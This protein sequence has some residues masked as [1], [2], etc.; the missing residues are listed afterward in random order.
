MNR[1]YVAPKGTIRVCEFCK[2]QYKQKTTWQRYCSDTCTTKAYRQRNGLPIVPDFAQMKQESFI[3]QQKERLRSDNHRMYELRE[4]GK[5]I[6]AELRIVDDIYKLIQSGEHIE[7]NSKWLE[8]RNLTKNTTATVFHTIMSSM[9]NS[10]NTI[11]VEHINNTRSRLMQEYK[12]IKSE[13]E[14]I[15]S[16]WTDVNS[17]ESEASK[18]SDRIH[19]ANIRKF[20]H[21][22][23]NTDKIEATE[24]AVVS[25]PLS[26]SDIVN[27][28][29]TTLYMGKYDNLMGKVEY[30]TTIIISGNQGSGKTTFSLQ[31]C[32][33]F[34][35]LGHGQALYISPEQIRYTTAGEQPTEALANVLRRNNIT[36]NIAFTGVKSFNAISDRILQTKA[37]LVVIDS[38]TKTNIAVEDRDNML[39]LHN[40]IMFMF[41]L[42]G[43]KAG[44][45]RGSSMWA[46]DADIVLNAEKGTIESTKNRYCPL[47]KHSVF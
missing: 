7:A 11:M 12:S 20:R 47:A 29:Y 16:Y 14:Q 44:K 18:I 23:G 1:Q 13:Y 15:K 24:E 36:Q 32:D 40:N 31:L 26:L 41:I 28:T 42:Q 25:S 21:S 33:E 22:V 37:K 43:T 45:Y 10:G 19:D 6:T 17:I 38:I 46:F 3:A 4:I 2:Q 39:R 8:Y 27:K 9:S 34:M 5:K 30:N 35:R